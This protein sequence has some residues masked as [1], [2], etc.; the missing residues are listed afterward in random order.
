MEFGGGGTQQQLSMRWSLCKQ[1]GTTQKCY[2]A[3]MAD[4]CAEASAREHALSSTR[5]KESA[6]EHACREA[7]ESNRWVACFSQ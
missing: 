3:H 6:T 5:A 7:R 2:R 4:M 1:V